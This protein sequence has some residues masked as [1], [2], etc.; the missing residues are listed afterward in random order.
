[1][2]KIKGYSRRKKKAAQI[3]KASPLLQEARKGLAVLS[4]MANSD[5]DK[6]QST[7]AQ[8]ALLASTLNLWRHASNYDEVLDDGHELYDK[9]MEP[10]SETVANGDL[11]YG[12]GTQFLVHFRAALNLAIVLAHSS[13]SDTNSAED[14]NSRFDK[15]LQSLLTQEELE[16]TEEKKVAAALRSLA[17]A[18]PNASGVYTDADVNLMFDIYQSAAENLHA[19]TT[20]ENEAEDP[21]GA[22]SVEVCY[23]IF[24]VIL[25]KLIRENHLHVSDEAKQRIRRMVGNAALT[26]RVAHY[27]TN[28]F[29][30]NDYANLLVWPFSFEG[31]AL[32]R[33]HASRAA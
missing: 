33:Q 30:K 23:F 19:R 8:A 18:F 20:P 16:P 5:C 27:E 32:L 10:G 6:S 22:F 9:V 15:V 13:A 14:A 3:T 26:E 4:G 2:K 28:I 7:V 1:M 21:N 12:L 31:K 25:N 11:T 24:C 17:A 29:E